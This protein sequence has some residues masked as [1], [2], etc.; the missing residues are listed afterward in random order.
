MV[1]YEG[2]QLRSADRVSGSRRALAALAVV[3][4]MLHAPAFAQQQTQGPN[5]P[6]ATFND[7]SFGTAP[8]TNPGNAEVS[9]DVFATAAPGGGNTQYLHANNFNFNVPA[10][11]L[12]EG[13]EVHIEKRSASGTVKDSRVRIVKGGVI[14]STDRSDPG[15][16]PTTKTTVTHGT[17]TDLWGETW[18][19]ADINASNFGV[20]I[21]ATDSFDTAGIDS[22]SITVYYSLCNT[23]PAAGC[24]TAAKS[25]F[26]YK[27]NANDTKD[28]LVWKFIKGDATT[29]AEFQNP[30][31]T[32]TY[33]LCLYY[34]GS[35][36][37][38]AAVAPD[39]A[40]WTT[41]STKGYKYKD[42]AGTSSGIQKVTLKGGAAGK[43]KVLV[44]GKGAALPDLTLM[45]TLPITVQLIN[46]DNGTC[47]ESTFSTALKNTTSQ[48]KAKN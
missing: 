23:A 40:K 25:L 10:P 37:P 22:F 19:A 48:V 9:D 41:I 36:I 27:N 44:K 14:G 34:A 47:W 18:T 24:K 2:M 26:L 33:A 3:A 45:A 8:W 42:T 21:S 29:Q 15:F 46:G 1:R 5:F 12:I 7:V 32:A 20:V 31:A 39:A 11:A 16:W 28:K 4:A 6:G 43:T 35:L 17:P 38:S 30:T 13:I